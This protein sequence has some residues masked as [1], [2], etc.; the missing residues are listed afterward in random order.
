M[1]L[2]YWNGSGGDDCEQWI[3]DAVA[4]VDDIGYAQRTGN[5]PFNTAYAAAN[6]YD[7]FVMRFDGLAA[8]ERWIAAGI[9]LVISYAW[10]PGELD[11]AP[12]ARSD[13]QL[14]VLVGFD[15][16]GNPIV[17]DPT[18]PSNDQAQVT[19]SREQFE[20]RWL[21]ASAGMAY[22]IFPVGHAIPTR[23]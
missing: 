18:F 1:V 22:V 4:G 14:A 13:G 17:I 9:P 7:A 21:E 10:E 19:Y 5:W 6:G 3:A 11:G 16:D 8:A 12:T 23:D 15:A 20:A 2:E